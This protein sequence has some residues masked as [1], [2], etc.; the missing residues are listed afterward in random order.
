M[1]QVSTQPVAQMRLRL[2]PYSGEPIYQQIVEQVKYQVACGRLV[3]SD[4]LPSIRS[5]AKELK[6]NPRTVVRAY[7][8]LAHSGLVVLRQGQGVFVSAH[9]EAAP[10]EA[11]RKVLGDMSRRLLAEAARM[12]ADSDEVLQ[13]LRE[14]TEQMEV[15]A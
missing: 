8:E 15:K 1:K 7:E 13:I 3:S 14:E 11:R 10:S 6:I 4:Q 9:R 12:G 5:L 2:D